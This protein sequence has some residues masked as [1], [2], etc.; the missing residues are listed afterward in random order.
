[1]Y[2]QLLQA[3]RTPGQYQIQIPITLTGPKGSWSGDMVFDT[4]DF[5]LMISPDVAAQLGLPHDQSFQ[6]EGV[7]GNEAAYYSTCGVKLGDQS[8]Q[9]VNCFVA[10]S[11]AGQLFGLRFLLDRQIG[12]RF[13]PTTLT[14]ELYGT[15]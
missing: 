14:V 12:F 15:P 3:I 6:V 2:R 13:D 7:T 11:Q 10:A 1:M 9:D 4:G 5:E 8:W